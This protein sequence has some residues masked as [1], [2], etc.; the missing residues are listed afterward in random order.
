MRLIAVVLVACSSPPAPS[1][2]APGSGVATETDAAP[3]E[4]A[5]RW[6]AGD[7]H[8]HVAPPDCCDV[9]LSA[10]DI[11]AAARAADMDFV[12]LTPHLWPW[13]WTHDKAKFRR[14]WRAMAD[15]ARMIPGITLIPGIEW[16]TDQGHFTVTGVDI[17]AMGD[18][19]LATAHAAGA[20]ISVNH[21]FAVPT[22][23]PGIP[24][25]EHDMSYR[26]WT[27]HRA[28]FTAIDGVE[29]WN[30]PLGFANVLSRPGGKTGEQNAWLAAD[31]VVHA[32]QR[33][34]TAVGGT[35]NHKR[36]VAATTWVLAA[37]ASEASILAALH[38][39]RTC[40]GGP[41]GGSLRARA[42]GSAWARIGDVVHASG[43][44][45]LTWDG[46]ARLFV[47]GVDR[48]EHDGGFTHDTHGELHTYRIEV[49]SSRCGFIYANL[50]A[51]D[52]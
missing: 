30:V 1:T 15:H 13:R 21:P 22:R 29:V 46:T 23:I 6:F 27:D 8:M 7:V 41:G 3:A 24:A 12:V 34:L 14:E 31:R 47:D 42:D 52:P 37:D 11:A 4:P 44:I 19:M 36:A 10:D 48:G 40:V 9:E 45:T 16:T 25:S 26:V 20:F 33:K 39:G 32:E 51:R 38:A 43:A 18:D 28:G 2:A 5:L 50:R 49:G 17:D 35:D